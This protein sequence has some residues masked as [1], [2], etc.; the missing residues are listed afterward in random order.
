MS[1]K[2]GVIGFGSQAKRIIKIL[3]KSGKKISYIYKNNIKKNYNKK[4]TN[5]F[6]DLKKCNIIFICSPNNTHFHYIKK[7]Y[8]SRY[9]FC[10]KPP[11]D[12][13]SDLKS[14]NKLNNSKIYYNFNYRFSKINK[15]ISKTK[16]L[17]FGKLIYGNIIF[18]HGLATKKSYKNTWRSSENKQGVYDIVGIHLIDLIINNFKIIDIK[19][20]LVNLLKNNSPDNSFF[21]ARLE[22]SAQIDCFTSY[23]S[24]YVQKFNFIYE[25]GI[26]EISNQSITF[27]GPR[28]T[29]DKKGFFISPKTLSKERLNNTKDYEKSLKQSVN[30]FI[31]ISGNNRLFDLNKNRLSLISNMLLLKGRI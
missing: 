30:Y 29:F 1:K 21:T 11:V 3:E 16:N 31:K 23:T 15:S 6:G 27:K 25:N 12:K 18:G 24:P 8:K 2:I 28:N 14:L 10:E 19:K 9:L 20:K 5:K 17:N 13:I 26:L 4:L 22:D 7:L